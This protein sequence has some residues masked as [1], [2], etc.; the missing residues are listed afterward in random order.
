[1]KPLNVLWNSQQA[2][3]CNCAGC[4]RELLGDCHRGQLEAAIATRQDV[5]NYPPLVA[6]R[7]NERPYCERCMSELE[8]AT[9]KKG[10][11]YG[12]NSQA[13]NDYRAI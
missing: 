11:R 10:N 4:R 12:N 6:G 5:D 2:K 8:L 9:G 1:M 3:I 13:G 7:Y